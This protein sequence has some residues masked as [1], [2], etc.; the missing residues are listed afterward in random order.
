M[1]SFLNSDNFSVFKDYMKIFQT[2]FSGLCTHQNLFKSG[3]GEK[4]FVTI[5]EIQIEHFK[6]E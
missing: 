3:F 1:P 6:R 4:S 5:L 2:M